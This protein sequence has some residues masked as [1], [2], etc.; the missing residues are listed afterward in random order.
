[1]YFY[2]SSDYPAALKLNGGYFG[3]IENSVKACNIDLSSPTLVEVCPLTSDGAPV[4]LLLDD[5]F[6]G[7]ARDCLVTD[8]KGGYLIKFCASPRD[9]E[10]KVFAQKKFDDACVTIFNDNGLKV[11]IETHSDFFADN[12]PLRCDSAEIIRFNLDGE[13]LLA[14]AVKTEQT[15]L[16]SYSLN[17][18]VRKL[19]ER[20]VENF[21]FDGGFVTTEKFTDMAKHKVV[22]EW[23][24]QTGALKEKN[25][26]VTNA[27]GFDGC[28]LPKPLLPFAFLEELLVGGDVSGYITGNVRKNADKLSGFFGK[29][30]GV[31]PPPV[32]REIDQVGLVYDNGNGGYYVDYF[33]FEFESGK[34]S[35]I[36]KCDD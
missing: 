33:T 9:S 34:I 24:F 16:Y 31:M 10:F 36:K 17:G 1:M 14:I 3:V 27:D 15:V 35:N 19:F 32:F 21:S 30:L 22:S 29:F 28:N 26:T 6:N 13:S 5:K 11:S 7:I 20:H 25:R 18:G 12:L 2:F 23:G 4:N 8:L